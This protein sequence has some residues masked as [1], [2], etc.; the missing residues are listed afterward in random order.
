MIN[1]KRKGKEHESALV[2]WWNEFLFRKHFTFETTLPPD[3]CADNLTQ[4]ETQREDWWTE[5][6]RRER[7]TSDVYKVDIDIYQFDIQFMRRG[8]G[9]YQTSAQAAGTIRPNEQ[10]GAW[11]QGEVKLNPLM[12]VI[13]V[14]M[15]VIFGGFFSIVASDIADAAW[16]LALW[17]LIML[18]VI[19]F[20]WFQIYR[21]RNRIIEQ[22]R[23]MVLRVKAKR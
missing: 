12:Q 2:Y 23:D 20:S 17:F 19:I 7:Q 3:V 11:V 1:E 5:L 16:F 13:L 18:A 9:G 14:V 21:D 6:W 22:I 4:I 15:I 10:G 8:K